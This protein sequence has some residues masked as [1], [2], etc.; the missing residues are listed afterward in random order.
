M[1]TGN[2]M[3]FLQVLLLILKILGILFASVLALVLIAVALLLFVPLRYRIQG[4][5]AEDYAVEARLSWLLR[6][7]RVK[8]EYASETKLFYEV[9]LLWF[10]LLSNDEAWNTAHEEKKKKK[11]EK[12]ARKAEKKKQKQKE[13]RAKAKAK[14][15]EKRRKVAGK[16]NGLTERNVKSVKQLPESPK[17]AADEKTQDNGAVTAGQLE[18][19]DSENE[20]Q[21]TDGVQQD[22]EKRNWFFRIC[23]KIKVVIEKIKKKLQSILDTIKILWHKADTVI[24]FLK[25]ETNKAAFGASWS[26]LVQILKHMGPT[27]IQGYLA[28][29][30]DDPAT[31]GYIL[32]VLGIFYSKFGKSFSIRPNFEEKQFETELRAKGRV[33]MSRL[34]FLAWKLWKNKEFKSLLDHIKQLKADIKT[35]G[36]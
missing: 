2:G 13:K 36:G 6:I 8:V 33:R 20:H 35:N 34:L 24:L 32:A 17:N 10:L 4:H 30:M 12:K 11:A 14:Q 19:T 22:G 3:G 18:Q 28:F 16:Q 26:T 7:I 21:I 15:R 23:D 25:E 27:K 9:R 1:E 5:K 29:G 31:T